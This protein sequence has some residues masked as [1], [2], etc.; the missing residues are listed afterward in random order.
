MQRDSKY[1]KMIRILREEL[2]PAL[3]C[4]EP[5]AIA[6]T[7][8]KAREVL[9]AFPERMV[10][11]C[12]G[13]IIKNT[14]GVIVP[15]TGN[16]RGIKASAIAGALAGDSS[17]KLE[18]LTAINDEQIEKTRELLRSDFCVEKYL[19]TPEVLHIVVTA[20][21]R[22]DA[23]RV[24]LKKHHT[25]IVR[26][27]KNDEVVFEAEGADGPSDDSLTDRGFLSV[28]DIYEFARTV[29]I[30]DVRDLLDKQI[31][32]NLRIA[33]EGL[34]HSYGAGVGSTLIKEFGDKDAKILARA[35]AAAGSDAR[36]S[37]CVLPVVINSG[38]GN[39]GMTVS[40]PVIVYARMLKVSDEKLYRALVLSNL[41]AIHQKTKIGP[42][43]RI[44]RR[45]KRR[46]RKRR[47]DHLSVRRRSRAD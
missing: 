40:L 4:T 22:Q 38:S 35:Y 42:A 33:E 29:D 20:V 43:V 14:K 13:N 11:E 44:L 28:R 39:Q 36:M 9:G 8:A 25:G 19:D 10:V 41:V 27:T 2:V 45:G 15:N 1:E 24:E 23:V 12:S 47:C 3:G 26:I 30:S 6:Y 46:L 16:L 34:S 37:G 32:Y 21:N 18:V 17:K 5:I 31:T 7:A